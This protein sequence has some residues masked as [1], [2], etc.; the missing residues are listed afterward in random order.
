MAS[1]MLKEEKTAVTISRETLKKIQDAQIDIQ[2]ETRKR[3]SQEA[4]ILLALDALDEKR[5]RQN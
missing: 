2:S 3:L 1:E 4:V 5:G